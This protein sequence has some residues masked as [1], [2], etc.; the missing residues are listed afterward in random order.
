[1][2]SK[3]G[4]NSLVAMEDRTPSKQKEEEGD[5]VRK[6]GREVKIGGE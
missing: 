6:W 5:F 1:M 2:T 3:A 4:I